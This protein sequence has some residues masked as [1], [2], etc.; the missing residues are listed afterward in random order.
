MNPADYEVHVEV[1]IRN[2][3]AGGN[4]QLSETVNIPDCS[5]SDM[6]GILS[7]FHELA[8]SLKAAKE[9]TGG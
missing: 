7:G 4:L 5:F 6:A 1:S 3:Q 2:Y 8:L 9:K